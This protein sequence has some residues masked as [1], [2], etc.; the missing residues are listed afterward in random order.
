MKLNEKEMIELGNFLAEKRKEKGYTLEELRLKL[1]SRGLIAEKSDIQRIENAERKLP[2]PILLSHLA[3]IYDFDIVEVYKKIGYLPKKDRNINFN[4]NEDHTS[5]FVSKST[6]DIKIYPT[7]L[8]LNNSQQI[9]VYSSLSIALGDFSDVANSGEFSIFLP[10]NENIKN[11]R[12]IGVKDREN[13][14]TIINKDS[15]VKNNEKGV[16]YFN[17][18]WIIA[19]KKISNREEIFLID[20]KKDCPIYVRNDDNFKEMGKIICEINMLQ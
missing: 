7:D 11:D 3:N 6:D 19:T 15:K 13:K 18:S 17:K 10:I 9:K 4:I 2:N 14:I 1:K 5:H 16:F 20:D 12:I 8:N